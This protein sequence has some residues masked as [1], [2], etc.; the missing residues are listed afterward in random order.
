MFISSLSQC[1][2]APSPAAD[3]FF[4]LIFPI[5]TNNL[6]GQVQIFEFEPHEDRPYINRSNCSSVSLWLT[7]ATN[8]FNN[9]CTGCNKSRRDL[10]LES[11]HTNLR[12]SEWI[13]SCREGV[14]SS[15]GWQ[16]TSQM[17]I[18]IREA[19]CSS[20]GTKSPNS[21]MPTCSVKTNN[22]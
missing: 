19:K 8:N 6:Q 12:S 15:R 1:C 2:K 11:E 14:R 3:R 18:Y 16:P 20:L 9:I 22:Y 7:N 21:L 13:P 5:A 17:L 4:C 10:R